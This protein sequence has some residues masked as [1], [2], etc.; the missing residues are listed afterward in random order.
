MKPVKQMSTPLKR[1]LFWSLFVSFFIY[2]AVVLTK[3][4]DNDKGKDFLTE[5]AK[6]GKLLYQKY[7]CTACHQLY[8]LGGYMGPDLTNTISAAGKG[9]QFAKAILMGGT[10]KMPNFH[11]PEAEINALVAYLNYVDKT[12]V[13]NPRHFKINNDGT[14]EEERIMT[15]D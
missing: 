15:N 7:N 13:S 11:L 12:G 8:G 5:E 6:Q 3:G 4:T 1:L 2:T 9:E 10:Q 14:V